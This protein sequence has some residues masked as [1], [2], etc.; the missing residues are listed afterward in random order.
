[1]TEM[2]EIVEITTERLRLRQWTPADREPWANMLADPRV[3]AYF[4]APL[5]RTASDAFADRCQAGIVER[6]WG[7]WAVERLSDGRFIGMVGLNVPPAALPF[8]PCVEIG[9]RLAHDCWGKGYAFEAANG[10]LAA[11]FERLGLSEI[12]AFTTLQNRRS[13]ALM[14]RLGMRP[15]PQEEFDHPMLTA[16]SP[17]LKHC[18]YRLSKEAWM[19][20]SADANKR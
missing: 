9:W 14:E 2:T 15:S 3:M 10:A 19:T 1:M 6:G 16:D 11:G 12:V 17:L 5:D 13:R 20:R 7:F 18:L 4:P 8:S